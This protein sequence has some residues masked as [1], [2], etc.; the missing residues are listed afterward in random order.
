VPSGVDKLR[1]IGN[2]LAV[3]DEESDQHGLQIFTIKLGMLLNV[4]KDDQ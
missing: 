2:T 4:I 3:A 1:G